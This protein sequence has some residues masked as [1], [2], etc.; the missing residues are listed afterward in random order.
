M[1]FSIGKPITV[2]WG[3]KET[4]FHGSEGKEAAKIKKI[5][6]RFIVLSIIS[7]VVDSKTFDSSTQNRVINDNIQ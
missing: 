5:V 3:S 7:Y 1:F 4:Q 2:G 6:S